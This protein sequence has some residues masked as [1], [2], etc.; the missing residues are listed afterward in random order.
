MTSASSRDLP[1]LAAYPL[2]A[3]VALASMGGLFGDLYTHETANWAAQGVGQDW[4]DLVFAVPWLVLSGIF[5]QR[6]SRAAL[7]LLA[8]GLVYTFYEFVIYAF[9]LHFNSLFLVYCA[10][11]GLSFFSLAGIAL[12]FLRADGTWSGPTASARAAGI[13]LLVVGVLFGLLWLTDVITALVHHTVPPAIVEAG[14]PTNPVYVMDL[15]I[16]L[17]L[18]FMTGWALLR[19]R[20]WGY[21]L[22][23][24]L[25]AF[26]VLM[27]LSI[28]GMM[29]VTRMRGIDTSLGIAAALL[30]VSAASGVLL[31]FLLRGLPGRAPAPGRKRDRF[32]LELVHRAQGQQ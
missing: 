22:G 1:I 4:V 20:P 8:G 26:G 32:Q 25:L 31:S 29:L 11:L 19:R 3:L 12:S 17:P 2:A 10:V 21:I 5:A 16:V 13:F 30:L 6:G 7:L 27:L 15:S 23:P 18:H 24:I 28:G 9:A 14:T